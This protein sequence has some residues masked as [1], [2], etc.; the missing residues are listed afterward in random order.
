MMIKVMIPL[1]FYSISSFV[2]ATSTWNCRNLSA[3][4]T[5]N[6]KQCEINQ[7]GFTPFDISTNAK[8]EL[9]VC[10]YS[11]CWEGKA[12][13]FNT[14][15]Y[16]VLAG[17]ALQWSHDAKQTPAQFLLNIDTRTKVG[18]LQGEGFAMPLQCQV[19]Y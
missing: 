4:I 8:N 2:W 16:L 11:G 9:T 3:E 19:S 12:T 6:Q 14:K 17:H 1:F 5:C 10:A 15:N 13:A 7:D 18:F